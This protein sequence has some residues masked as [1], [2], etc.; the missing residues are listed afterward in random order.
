M[1][2]KEHRR[3]L[4]SPS[5]NDQPADGLSYH[6]VDTIGRNMRGKFKPFWILNIRQN[7]LTEKTTTGFH[8]H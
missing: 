5:S 4:V 6:F 2:S 7:S 1:P 8:H 3:D